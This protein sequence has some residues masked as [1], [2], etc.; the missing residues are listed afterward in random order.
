[1]RIYT[2]RS[3]WADRAARPEPHNEPSVAVSRPT[4]REVPEPAVVRLLVADI[5]LA[6]LW[7]L[8]RL[9]AG[10]AWLQDGYAKLADPAGTWVGDRAGAAIRA[11]VTGALAG[12]GDTP[13]A[14]GWYAALLHEVVLPHAAAFAYV[15]TLGEILAGIALI[16]GL[17]TGIAAFIG[18]T[19]G[20]SSLLAGAVATNPLLFVAAVGLVLAWRV[21]GYY[22]LD[23]WALPLLGVLSEPGALFR[24]VAS[25][26]PSGMD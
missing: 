25:G 17:C 15:V 4:T 12:G 20:A 2:A 18:G 8:L 6:P 24:R 5:R 11:S 22:G 14:T 19:V 26:R 16:V 9:Y 21:A 7:L 1:M 13:A 23:R 10:Y 3:G